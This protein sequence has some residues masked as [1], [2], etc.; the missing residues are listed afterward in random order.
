MPLANTITNATMK[1]TIQKEFGFEIPPKTFVAVF[2]CV[3]TK[4]GFNLPKLGARLRCTD[5]VLKGLLLWPQQCDNIDPQTH[6][7]YTIYIWI[8]TYMDHNLLLLH[9]I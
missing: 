9:C 6:P 5:K 1:I 7:D 3:V 2:S 4:I 8:D